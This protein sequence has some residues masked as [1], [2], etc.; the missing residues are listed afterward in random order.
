[1][2]DQFHAPLAAIEE[3]IKIS[4]SLSAERN[5]HNLLNMIV[6]SAR[7]ITYS[8]AGNIYILDKTKRHLYFEVSQNDTTGTSIKDLPPVPL[9]IDNK[10]NFANIC[11]YCAFSGKVINIPDVYK[12][13]GFN[14]TEIYQRDQITGY[15]SKSVLAVPLRN[16]EGITI[17]VLE[18]FNA[19]DTNTKEVTPFPERLEGVVTAFASQA[20]VA[21][22]NMQLIKEN[23]HLIEI[24]QH[25]NQTLEQENLNL[26]NKLQSKYRFS[27]IIGK[28]H[29]MQK[30]FSLMEK[31]LDSDATVLINGETGC[32]KELVAK[33]IHY[34]GHRKKGPFI[35]QN[36]A[37][38]PENLLE[39][40]LF[41]YH[42]GAFTG[43][44]TDKKGLMEIASG[45]TLFLDEIGDMPVGIQAKLLRVLQEGE[46]RP[47]GSV[48]NIKINIRVIAAT[49]CDLREKIKSGNFR[50]DLYYRLCVFPVD[51]P[52]LRERKDDLPGLIEHFLKIFAD[53][54]KTN[55]PRFS[56]EAMD[57]ILSYD[58]PGN[59]RE[60]KNL[61]ERLILLANKNQPILVEYLPDYIR[62]IKHSH[63]SMVNHNSKASTL[64]EAVNIFEANIIKEKLIQNKWNQTK[65][66]KALQIPRRTLIEKMS[67]FKLYSIR[68]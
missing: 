11:S 54:Y 66:A 7:K 48:K 31:V 8:D 18:L 30:V 12:Y 44:N 1:M 61:L 36:C 34:N 45:G 60:L 47:L 6:I 41:G 55:I 24:L 33:A 19:L 63:F 23:R 67:R 43:A 10:Q 27:R 53:Q 16:H 32:G 3:F 21:I 25:T 9:F 35:A 22:N 65:T 17:G 50:E 58:F 42:R 15:R 51:I 4:I 62:D 13:S 57:L 29:K 46:V 5:L 59:I 40:E 28:S 64:K 2:N 52:P 37:A 14:F 20:A 49:H 26:R 56:P 68:P 39:S 38:L